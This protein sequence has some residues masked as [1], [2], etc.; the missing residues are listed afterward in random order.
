MSNTSDINLPNTFLS[1]AQLLRNSADSWSCWTG[2]LTSV[3]VQVFPFKKTEIEGDIDRVTGRV[4][5]ICIAYPPPPDLSFFYFGLFERDQEHPGLYFAGG[6]GDPEERLNEGRLSY[7]PQNRFLQ[8]SLVNAV[9]Q[10]A[11]GQR[12]ERRQVFDYILMF[13]AAGLLAKF[14]S[15]AAGIQFPVFTGFD[16]GD[17]AQVA[18]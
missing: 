6:T 16:S 5:Q 14:S 8:S 10:A 18:N 12:S 2:I 3:G 7:F 15:I 1:V 17:F 4:V 9:S 13:G 11:A